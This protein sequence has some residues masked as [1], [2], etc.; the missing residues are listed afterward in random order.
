MNKNAIPL[1]TVCVPSFNHARYVVQC[2]E[3]ISKSNHENLEL[4]IIDDGSSDN[5]AAIISEWLGANSFRFNKIVFKVQSNSGICVTLNRLVKEASGEYLAFIAS[6]DKMIA[7]GISKRI[8]ELKSNPE[9]M[10]V[11][12]DCRLIDSNDQFISNSAIVFLYKA[13]IKALL[14]KNLIARELILNWS[15]PG[16]GF[17]ARVECFN[18]TKGIG[19]YNENIPFEDRDFYLR[20]LSR[21][22]L[23]FINT[24]VAEYRIHDKN[25]SRM[26]NGIKYTYESI[27]PIINANISVL[28]YFSGV[29]KAVL[30]LENTYASVTLHY[31]IR[32]RLNL[33]AGRVLLKSVK[34]IIYKIHSIAIS[35]AY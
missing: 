23:G 17:M 25:V 9:W 24:P 14:Q 34:F 5:S 11:Y 6:D 10:A 30:W 1:V 2:L 13:N 28:Q 35:I 27:K 8:H 31:L 22:A 7:D 21:K 4:V 33:L 16:P 15:V 12:G 29:D 3:S 18:P 26:K 32:R 19:L 20:L